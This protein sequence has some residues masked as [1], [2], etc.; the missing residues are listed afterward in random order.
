MKKLIATIATA[1]C[2]LQATS[3]LAQD[4]DAAPN[5]REQMIK[6]MQYML[7]RAEIVRMLAAQHLSYIDENRDKGELHVLDDA[8][9]VMAFSLVCQDPDFDPAMLNK[10]A[11]ESTL[12]IALKVEG[13]PIEESISQ[14]MG[15][16]NSKERITLVA[17]V[18]SAALMFK[19][20]RR[21]GL[22]DA[23]LTDFGTTRFCKGMRSNMRARY[24]GLATYLEDLQTRQSNKAQ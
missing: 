5:Q 21:R 22:F 19:V 17:D 7:K 24:Q 1:A 12:Q 14:I 2:L 23:L 4:E 6:S 9:Q 3:A 10:I 18:S 20:G 15:E 13:S 11:A 8:A 16:L